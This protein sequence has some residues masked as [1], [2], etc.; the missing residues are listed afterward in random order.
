MSSYI[1]SI[2][3]GIVE[4]FTEFLP[5]S[6][7]AHL[8]LVSEI[9]KISQTN[10]TKTFEIAIQSG[11]ILAVIVFYWRKFI[12]LEILKRVIVAFI[13]TGII[14][15]LLYKFVREFLLGNINVVLWALALGGIV[16]VFFERVFKEKT[17]IIE[18]KDISYGKAIIIGVWQSVAI[19]PGVSRSAA[20]IIGGMIVG[21]SRKAIVE[22]SFLLAVPTMFAATSLDILNNYTQFSSSQF[23]SLGIGLLTAFVTAVLGIKFFLK[24][25]KNH[26]FVVFGIYRIILVV[27]FI[28]FL[29]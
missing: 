26:S 22:F 9:L 3:L 18:I 13:P 14:G 24:Y 2:V 7:T 17:S 1:Y 11:A 20:T 12:D 10:F 28:L 5:I 19:I 15:L 23:F 8:V 4:G 6:S 27:V 29:L 21:V 25:I 16:L